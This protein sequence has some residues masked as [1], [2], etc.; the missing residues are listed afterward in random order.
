M[1]GRHG[2]WALAAN[3]HT[4]DLVVGGMSRNLRSS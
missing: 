2:G 4:L 1:F 3:G